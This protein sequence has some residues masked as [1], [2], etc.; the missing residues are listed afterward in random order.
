MDVETELRRIRERNARVEADKAWETSYAR[1]TIITI[2]TYLLS[3]IL[4]LVIEAP[5]PHLAALV[6]SFAFILS[7]L[8]MPFLK[9]LWVKK[10]VK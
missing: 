8:S 9:K 1:R 7:T 2:G 6:P 3:Y 4:F 10:H 5:N